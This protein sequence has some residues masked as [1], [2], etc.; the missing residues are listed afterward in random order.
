MKFGY[1]PDSTDLY[2]I[3]N[4][5][6]MAIVD[7]PKDEYGISV[8]VDKEAATEESGAVVQ[9][10]R[11]NVYI[12]GSFN[13]D[14]IT[15]YNA[16]PGNNKLQTLSAQGR[17][18]ELSETGISNHREG[19]VLKFNYRG[20]FMFNFKAGGN[21]DVTPLYIDIGP[22]DNLCM[23]GQM[24]TDFARFSEPDGTVARYFRKRIS[25]RGIIYP[26]GFIFKYRTADTLILPSD[27]SGPI[28]KKTIMNTS[29]LPVYICMF[30]KENGTGTGVFTGLATIPGRSSMVFINTGNEWFPDTSNKLSS[31]LLSVNKDNA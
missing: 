3:D 18:I 26:T 25:Q 5:C 27:N 7:G 23:V 20:V 9:D 28:Y 12:G 8:V 21:G 29:S 14:N 2:A 13:S 30:R 17:I 15:V 16:N 31:D 22:G 24:A 1:N 19:F 10:G 11:Y 6:W 4:I